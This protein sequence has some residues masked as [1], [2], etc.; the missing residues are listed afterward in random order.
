MSVETTSYVRKPFE[1]SAV[2]VTEENMEDVK[3]WCQGVVEYEGESVTR[4]FIRVR[5][6]RVLSERQTKAYVGD[7][8]LYAATGFKVYTQKAFHKTFEPKV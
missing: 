5:V 8:V 3:D 6:A 4:R 7:W 1:V 2:Q